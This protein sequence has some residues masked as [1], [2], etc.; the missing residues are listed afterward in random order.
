MMPVPLNN[1]NGMLNNFRLP[2]TLCTFIE[3]RNYMK[4]NMH[5]TYGE[6]QYVATGKKKYSH[7]FSFAKKDNIIRNIEIIVACVIAFIAGTGVYGMFH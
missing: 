4:K 5:Y 1:C 6:A 2:A 7:Y 3:N